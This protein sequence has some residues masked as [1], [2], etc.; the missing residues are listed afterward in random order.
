MPLSK[1]PRNGG[2]E[3][4]GSRSTTY[5]SLC[6][7]DGQFIHPDFTAE[8]MQTF[9]VE[10]LKKNGMPGFMAWLFTRGIPNLDRWRM[11]ASGH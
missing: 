9:C 4:D 10:Q 2:S 7:E 1:D 6:Y 11:K 3:K 5:C 8:E